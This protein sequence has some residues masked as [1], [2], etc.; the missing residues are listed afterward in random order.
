MGPLDLARASGQAAGDMMKARRATDASSGRA[1]DT[2]SEDDDGSPPPCEGIHA[3]FLRRRHAALLQNERF[4]FS[5]M[6]HIPF[7]LRYR[8]RRAYRRVGFTGLEFAMRK[9]DFD[10]QPRRFCAYRQRS[11]HDSRLGD[12]GENDLERPLKMIHIKHDAAAF[13]S[14]LAHRIFKVY[15]RSRNAAAG[16]VLIPLRL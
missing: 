15:R 1:H 11:G 10:A 12:A 2:G 13:F 7:S 4:D 3:E 14:R 9:P 6:L 16:A 5:P 8:R